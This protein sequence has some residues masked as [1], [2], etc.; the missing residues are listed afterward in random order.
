MADGVLCNPPLQKGRHESPFR[1]A[2]AGALA[3]CGG[4]CND[5]VGELALKELSS[6]SNRDRE[7]T[8]QG[9]G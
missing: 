7:S 8:I 6:I 2:V 4:Q 5:V 3:A 1:G 9:K